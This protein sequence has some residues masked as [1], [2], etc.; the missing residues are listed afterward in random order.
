MPRCREYWLD[1]EAVPDLD[2]TCVPVPRPREWVADAFSRGR[3]S[4]VL[5]LLTEAADENLRDSQVGGRAP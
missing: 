3:D 2:I 1:P 5:E 4:R